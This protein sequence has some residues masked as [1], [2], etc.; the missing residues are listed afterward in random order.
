MEAQIDMPR[1]M[2]DVLLSSG[3]DINNLR[4]NA[5]LRK[6]EWVEFDTTVVDVA[7]ARLNGVRDLQNRG[8]TL[9]LG[10]LGTLLSQYETQSDMTDAEISMAGV[11]PGREDSVEFNLL[12]VP[13]P[14]IHKDFR[15]NIRRLEASRRLGDSV[16]TVQ[17]AIAARKVADAIENM[18]FNGAGVTLDG[19]TIYG[20]TTHPDINT[21]TLGTWDTDTNI[22]NIYADVLDMVS[23]AQS[24]YYPGPYILYV[25]RSRWPS[26]LG[27]YD[28]GS[29]QTPLQRVQTI[30][31]IEAVKVSDALNPDS[32]LL[33]QMSRDVV[34]LAV[35][36]DITTVQWDDQGGMEV[37][38][39]V[40]A[41]LAPRIK[42]DYNGHSGIVYY[43]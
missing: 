12:S 17:A 30:P 18:L 25:G 15:V 23:D 7:R 3:L 34:D 38:F 39:K 35:A 5:V 28:D 14:I 1:T 16:D 19:N 24:V 13:I 29:G 40:M 10:G 8:L 21:G 11:T 43:T 33:V 41:A 42:S 6:E 31:G 26:M 32:A 22:E 36:Q 20:Y 27:Y 4:T 2:K 37:H 9:R